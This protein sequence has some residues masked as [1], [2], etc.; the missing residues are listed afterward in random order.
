MSGSPPM[1][2]P[3]GRQRRDQILRKATK[4]FAERGYH[5]TAISHILDGLNIA[6]GTFYQ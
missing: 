3:R 1:L 5:A 2:S 6:R 4:E